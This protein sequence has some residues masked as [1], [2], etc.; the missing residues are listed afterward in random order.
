[1]AQRMLIYCDF[2][3]V[4]YFVKFLAD[5]DQVLGVSFGN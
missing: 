4:W 3:M 2:H 5:L 1:M